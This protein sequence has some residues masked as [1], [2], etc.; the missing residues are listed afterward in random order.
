MRINEEFLLELLVE[1]GVL[2]AE[3][4]QKVQE[5]IENQ[6]ISVGRAVE[7]LSIMSAEDVLILLAAEYDLETV[8]LSHYKI[9]KKIIKLVSKE[10]AVKYSIIP[11]EADETSLT[12]AMADPT[13]IQVFD[14]LSHLLDTDVQGVI[15]SVDDIATA[16][17]KY[18]T[19]ITVEEF[20]EDDSE[21][22]GVSEVEEEI[23]VDE[24]PI[25]QLVSLFIV[26]AYKT[27]VSD[28]HLEP[29]EDR[30]RLRYRVDGLLEE[31]EDP[32]KYLQNNIISR[33]KIMAKLDISEKR[34]PQDGRISMRL[35]DVCLDLRVST[36]PTTHGESIVM[37]LLD[38]SNIK[39]G[40]PELGMFSDDQ[41]IIER[42]INYPD[43]IFLVTGPTGSGKTTSLYA[44]LNTLNQADRKIITA[45]DPI[46]YDLKGINQCQVDNVTG[47][48]FPKILRSM[49]RQAPNIIMI[50]EIRDNET[51]SI[52]IQASLT[53]H[54]V[55]STLH[56][57]DATSAIARL[58]DIGVQPFLVASALKAVMAQRL[59]RK[60]C[61]KCKVAYQ[62]SQEELEFLE[63]S[64]KKETGHILVVED[65]SA[66]QKLVKKILVR[67]DYKVYTAS[68]GVEAVKILED[69][70][71]QHIDIV[72]TD[73]NMP[74]MNGFELT[75]YINEKHSHIPVVIMSGANQDELDQMTE[76]SIKGCLLKPINTMHLLNT[77][78][79][80][81]GQVLRIKLE[82]TANQN[83][84]VFNWSVGEGCQ[85]CKGTGYKGRIG[86]YEI[87]HLTSEIQ[88]MVYKKESAA[89]LR[90]RA[91]GIG[92][93]T[94]RDDGVRKAA[95]GM[96]S[97][98]EVVRVSMENEAEHFN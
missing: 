64:Q 22:L 48:T 69:E 17:Q 57:N 13:D 75:K 70:E 18:Y 71:S 79:R 19:G 29:L 63:L 15:A 34:L 87:F 96:T 5:L 55:F 91:R 12:I 39:I 54:M 95:A 42:V 2:D 89:S 11:I 7:E 10:I 86:I 92:M 74:E 73:Y 3:S 4:L 40:I 98:E 25:V 41:E 85:A 62:P 78:V 9:S 27:E 94:L 1:N 24:T 77:L 59:V 68:N 50:G 49:L 80:I 43:G 51:A 93:R 58:V 56:T 61:E 31:V 23:D 20:E 32:P 46:E 35:K 67:N 88:E 72:L 28:I 36:I 30:L 26:K 44:F 8:K 6:D 97:I 33:L 52:A 82:D 66:T 21:V 83:Q 65:D 47:M 84:A 76:L 81:Y 37:R 90:A 60:I 16:L 53:G 14:A 38:K 45:E